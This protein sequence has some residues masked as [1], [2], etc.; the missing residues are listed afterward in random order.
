M[1]RYFVSKED[2]VSE[3][4]PLW[5]ASLRQLSE[6]QVKKGPL[7]I[8]HGAIVN[9][10]LESILSISRYHLL[11]DEL[12][13]IHIEQAKKCRPLCER[14]ANEL[15]SSGASSLPETFLVELITNQVQLAQLRARLLA[16]YETS[17]KGTKAMHCHLDWQQAFA[18]VGEQLLEEGLPLSSE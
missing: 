10:L 9:F 16:V 3:L 18:E 8:P 7:P 6:W 13:R 1:H 4:R 5:Q 14:E 17:E 12:D 15:I 2:S 11:I